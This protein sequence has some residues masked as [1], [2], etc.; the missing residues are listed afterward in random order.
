MSRNLRSLKIWGH[1][2]GYVVINNPVKH[3]KA[4]ACPFDF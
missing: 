3:N 2:D 1:L 4:C